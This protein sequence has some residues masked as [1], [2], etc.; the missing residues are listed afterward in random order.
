MHRP[1]KQMDA[2]LAALPAK[3]AD[4]AR[5]LNMTSSG[6]CKMLRIL[7]SENRAYIA[8]YPDKGMRR[9]AL[10]AAGPRPVNAPMPPEKRQP[11]AALSRVK[12]AARNKYEHVRNT[13]AEDATIARARELARERPANWCSVLELA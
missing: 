6:V 4:M 11:S 3:V 1:R 10:W 8:Q 12:R 2:V 7:E 5:E 9:G 13:Q